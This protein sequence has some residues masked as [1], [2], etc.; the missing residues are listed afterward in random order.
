MISATQ[1][2]QLADKYRPETKLQKRERLR[3]RAESRVEGK[4]DAPTKRPPVVR[5]GINSVTKLI[6]QKKAQLVII[7]HDVDPLE[8]SSCN[9]LALL[10][11]IQMK[12][13]VLVMI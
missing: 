8:V 5:S 2:F 6:E 7:A 1:L 12:S 9:K 13:G 11:S 3:A 4:E 10:S